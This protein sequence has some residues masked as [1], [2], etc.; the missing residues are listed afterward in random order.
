MPPIQLS[1]HDL[2]QL[3]VMQSQS[4]R[5]R[6]EIVHILVERG[7]PESSA[8]R[9]VITTLAEHK[10][11]LADE[12]PPARQPPPSG[13]ADHSGQETRLMF[14]AV[15]LVAISILMCILFMVAH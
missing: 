1:L 15:L 13:Q 8:T 11:L 5:T 4:G 14:L 2:S 7:W 3:V 6:E 9:F 12:F 10:L